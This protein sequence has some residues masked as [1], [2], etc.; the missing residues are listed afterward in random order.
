MKRTTTFSALLC[1]ISI[2][3][4]SLFASG[5]ATAEFVFSDEA[6][7]FVST[8]EANEAASDEPIRRGASPSAQF[9][10]YFV[11]TSWVKSRIN[12]IV[13]IDTRSTAKYAAGHIKGAINVPSSTYFFSRIEGTDGTVINYMIPTPTE[14]IKLMN[15][16]GIKSA[17]TIVVTYGDAD[18][19]DW[20]LSARLAWT[21]RL[22]GHQKAYHMDGGFPKW[23]YIDKY[24]KYST[25]TASQPK[26]NTSGY[27]LT[28]YSD[29]LATKYD[30]LAV[31]TGTATNTVIFDVRTPGE[32]G[33]TDPKSGNPRNG[34]I[35]N[36]VFLNW[37]DV[38]T[39]NAGGVKDPTTDT[40]IKVL[41][42]ESELLTLFTSLGITKDKTIVP[43][44]EGGFRSAHITY[45]LL[46]LGYPSVRHYQ[47]SW[48]EWSRQ[49]PAVYTAVT[50]E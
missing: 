3:L 32:Y 45:L 27:A 8:G 4:L 5:S 47:G 46:G 11:T 26:V 35:P 33:G 39:D 22:Y 2:T 29:I 15:S 49:D 42:S 24:T 44:C 18:D 50:P 14:F 1:I 13:L 21:M 23:Q 40:F 37:T 43:Y 17:S 28:G 30:V 19:A 41:K 7:R 31:V 38:F 10:K 12:G 34:H 6:G 16:W 20:G 36:A 9:S 25:T 48:S